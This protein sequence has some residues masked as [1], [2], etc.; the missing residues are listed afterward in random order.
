VA[1]DLPER[2]FAGL[3]RQLAAKG[4]FVKA[5][6]LLDASLI[7]ADV[8]RPPMDHGEV[9]ERDPDAGFTRRGQRSFFG[10]KAHLAVDQGTD[11]IRGAIL[12]GAALGDSLARRRGGTLLA[13]HNRVDRSETL[14]A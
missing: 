9:S 14:P 11:L 2:L 7:E 1:A 13:R 10:Y 8:K 5:G 12:T 4:L 6:T 3:D